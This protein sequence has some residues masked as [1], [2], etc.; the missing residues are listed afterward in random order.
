[1]TVYMSADEGKTLISPS[2][3]IVIPDRL[4]CDDLPRC[5]STFVYA[6]LFCAFFTFGFGFGR[7]AH[8]A[9]FCFF[10]VE[11]SPAGSVSVFFTFCFL[12]FTGSGSSHASICFRFFDGVRVRRTPV[13]S[14]ILSNGP[15]NILA[16]APW[17]V[18]VIRSF[19]ADT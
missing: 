9:I 18:V 17:F 3:S 16:G 12:I 5:H 11:D 2:L 7:T 4:L 8:S 1:M 13:R 14:T 19:C 15:D 6:A 10:W